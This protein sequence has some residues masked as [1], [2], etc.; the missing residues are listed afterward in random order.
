MGPNE[1]KVR[2]KFKLDI[3]R[4]LLAISFTIFALIISLNP[5]LLRQSF[6]V[7]IQLTLAIPLL[8]SSIFAR[9]KLAYAKKPRLWEDYGFYTFLI[10]YAF[11]MNVLGMLLSM[12]IGLVY[13]MI[14]MVFNIFISLTYSIIEVYEDK[15]TLT[16]RLVKDS[17]FITLLF[18]GGILPSMGIY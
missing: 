9:S 6:F 13:G 12:S 7:P 1:K 18:F 3:N 11:L 14:F 16:S 5:G 4:S 10:G 8:L 17:V 15:S 2:S